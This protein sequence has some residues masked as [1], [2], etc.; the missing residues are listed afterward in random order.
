MPVL[1]DQGGTWRRPSHGTVPATVLAATLFAHGPA[2]FDVDI[3]AGLGGDL[4][5][6]RGSGWGGAGGVPPPEK[7]GGGPGGPEQ[8]P[9]EAGFLVGGPPGTGAGGEPIPLGPGPL[10]LA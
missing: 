5:L 6:W 7:A 3:P 4:L 1:L 9:V 2:A 10:P 8:Q